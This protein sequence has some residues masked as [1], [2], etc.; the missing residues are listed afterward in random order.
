MSRHV[1]D[2]SHAAGQGLTRAAL[3]IEREKRPSPAT[4]ML[5]RRERPAGPARTKAFVEIDRHADPLPLD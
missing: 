4:L 1:L 3:K 2:R 5:Q